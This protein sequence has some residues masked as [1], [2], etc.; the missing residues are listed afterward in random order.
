[1][2]ADWVSAYSEAATAV[3]TLGLV[4]GVVVQFR[5]LHQQLSDVKEQIG[6]TKKAIEGETYRHLEEKF[7]H[8]E[9]M[10]NAR[11]EAAR[12]L[13]ELRKIIDSAQSAERVAFVKKDHHAFIELAGFF[14]YIGSLVRLGMIDKNAVYSSFYRKC[15]AFWQAGVPIIKDRRENPKEGESQDET[16]LLWTDF[17]SLSKILREEHVK[18]LA[19]VHPHEV[20]RGDLKDETCLEVLKQEAKIK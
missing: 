4:V 6:L 5:Q 7:F 16:R 19:E 14:D 9:A 18:T 15:C 2:D 11:Y 17:E 8:S 20:R 10:I 12:D 3:C 1:M 13:L